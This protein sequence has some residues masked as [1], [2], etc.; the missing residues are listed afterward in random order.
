MSDKETCCS[1]PEISCFHLRVQKAAVA[2][3]LEQDHA[4]SGTLN[5][6]RATVAPISATVIL[7]V[8]YLA[9]TGA[10]RHAP[11]PPPPPPSR[12]VSCPPSRT[13]GTSPYE[14][15]Y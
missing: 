3:L 9:Q 15:E 7:T 10:S 14:Y 1:Q 11:P 6:P 2:K 4:V 13:K 8:Q 5:L 12:T